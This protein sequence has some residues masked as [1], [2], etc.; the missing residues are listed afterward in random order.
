[1]SKRMTGGLARG[2]RAAMALLLAVALSLPA[3][4]LNV[5]AYA[6]EPM[7]PAAAARA[8]TQALGGDESE[9]KIAVLSDMHYYPVNFVSDCEDYKTYVGGDP[10][11]LE[12]SGSIADAALQMVREDNPDI[13]LVSGDL[14][15]DG[16]IQGHRDLAAKFQELEDD[17][18]T[19][20][21]VI[22]GNHDLYNYT[23]ACTF[24][25]G[26]K[27][28][29][30][31]AEQDDFK[32]IYKNFGY[33]GEYN[34]QYFENPKAAQGELAGQMSY[35]V[36]LGKFRIVAI[37]SCCYSPDGGNGMGTNEHIT[38]GRIDEDLMPWVVDQIKDAEEAGDTVIGLM[39]HGVVPHF[40]GEEDLL[41]EYVVDDWQNV[42]TQLADAGM[43]YVFTGHMHAN[44]ISQYTSVSGNTITDLE[45]GSLSSWMSPQRHVTITKGEP[46]GDGTNR[47]KESFSVTS[48]SVKS[49]DFTDHNGQ[50]Q[51]IEDFRAYTQQKLYPETLFNNMANGM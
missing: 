5:Q 33:N 36:D 2:F 34:A 22:N 4:A 13:L 38:A 19:E 14:T 42:A 45:T 24:E 8:K 10:K 30:E 23:D 6:D 46:L 28:S 20:V 31:T 1:M 11:M 37:D 18:D 16:E 9:I 15:K 47:T 50:T 26:K 41:Y 35:T 3:G 27:E 12:E 48:H 49:I 29:A 25:N 17:T 21:F 32:T 7:Q 51:H 43:R 40:Q 39:H 44:D